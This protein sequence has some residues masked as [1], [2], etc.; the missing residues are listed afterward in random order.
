MR[1]SARQRCV[2]ERG[3]GEK[4][5]ERENSEG[6]R[7]CLRSNANDW[8]NKRRVKARSHEVRERPT[9]ERGAMS[10]RETTSETESE[11]DKTRE[12]QRARERARERERERE[13][14]RDNKCETGSEREEEWE[15][16]VACEGKNESTSTG[17]HMGGN[18]T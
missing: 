6:E 16:A 2:C 5:S 13:R 8:Q 10:E 18:A 1:V 15:R 11:R 14:E 3:G 9:R 4:T 12:S 7:Q 17:F